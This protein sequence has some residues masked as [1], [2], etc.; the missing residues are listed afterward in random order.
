[1][2]Y[3]I[4]NWQNLDLEFGFHLACLNICQS[5]NI[6]IFEVIVIEKL[7]YAYYYQ[8][9]MLKPL[10]ITE[11]TAKINNFKWNLKL[12]EAKLIK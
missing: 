10:S 6:F 11:P 2:C 7:E 4:V 5:Y 1:M 12:E 8:L 3:I 9:K